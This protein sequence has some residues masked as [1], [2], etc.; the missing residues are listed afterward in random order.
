MGRKFQR[1][2]LVRRI[3]HDSGKVPGGEAPFRP[4]AHGL[5]LHRRFV[6]NTFFKAIWNIPV[7]GIG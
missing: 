7:R 2:G 3:N 1:I 6:V 5:I 4:M